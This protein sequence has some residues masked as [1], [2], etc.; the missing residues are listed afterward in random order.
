MTGAFLESLVRHGTD[1]NGRSFEALLESPC[2]HRA[3]SPRLIKF[4]CDV[5]GEAV[6]L[7]HVNL[8]TLGF[9]KIRF[10]FTGCNIALIVAH[11]Y[12]YNYFTKRQCPWATNI[13]S[14]L[15][16]RSLMYQRE[17]LLGRKTS[18]HP[19]WPKTAIEALG[20]MVQSARLSHQGLLTQVLGTFIHFGHDTQP[21]SE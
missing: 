7:N 13:T 8:D 12:W 5:F 16:I 6:L 9:T 2:K 20:N 1:L 10:W 11:N 4:A 14:S 19:S 18:A 21:P 15:T 17:P 3:F